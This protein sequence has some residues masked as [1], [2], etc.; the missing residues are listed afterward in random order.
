MIRSKLARKYAM[1]GVLGCAFGLAGIAGCDS[2]PA[3]PTDASPQM[4]EEKGITKKGKF[5]VTK[6]KV[7]DPAQATNPPATSPPAAK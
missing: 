1:M 7:T 6:G 5:A 3:P 2:T 4:P